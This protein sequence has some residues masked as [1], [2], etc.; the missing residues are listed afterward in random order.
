MGMSL[1]SS[2]AQE[3][4]YIDKTV[5]EMIALLGEPTGDGLRVIDE[6]YTRVEREPDYSTYFS[7]AER[8]AKVTIRILE[9]AKTS[10]HIIIWTKKVDDEWIVFSSL[11]TKRYALY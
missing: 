9:W 5:S 10:E 11:N 2:D 3:D 7:L 6:N 1:F 8:R 4:I